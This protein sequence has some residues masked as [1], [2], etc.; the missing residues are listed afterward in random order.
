MPYKEMGVLYV[1]S[2]YLDPGS[3]GLY[4]GTIEPLYRYETMKPQTIYID[5]NG[6]GFEP[7]FGHSYMMHGE[8]FYGQTSLTA[9]RLTEFSSVAAERA[10]IEGGA[11]AA[12]CDVSDVRKTVRDD[13]DNPYVKI[14]RVY[15]V[16][17]NSL[18]VHATSDMAAILTFH[19]GET[20]LLEGRAFTAAEYALGSRVCV[21]SSTTASI[22]GVGLGDK[23]PLFVVAA[24]DMPLYESYWPG[25]RETE[26]DYE[27]VGIVSDTQDLG[28]AVYIPKP[29]SMRGQTS[30]VGYTIG[31]AL[32]KNG[33]ADEFV[34]RITPHLTERMRLTVYDQGYAA[35]AQPIEEVRETASLVTVACVI[36]AA[37]VLLLFAYLFVYRQ[38]ETYEI[39][40]LT[41]ASARDSV[42]YL[43]VSCGVVA[44]LGAALGAAGGYLFADRLTVAM[45]EDAGTA[46]AADLRYST[47]GLGIV[48]DFSI[49]TVMEPSSAVF[50]WAAAAVFAAACAL[51]AGFLF[52][53]SRPASGR[54]V[55]AR[56]KPR[57]ARLTAFIARR[58]AKAAPRRSHPSGGALAYALTSIARGG[59]RSLAAPAA[60]LAITV[61]ISVISSTLA[62]YEARLDDVYDMDISAYATSIS[63]RAISGLAVAEEEVEYLKGT[64]YVTDV[65]VSV[66]RIYLYAGLYSCGDVPNADYAPPETPRS[67]Y[68]Y[69]TWFNGVLRGPSVIY[70]TDMAAS[71]EFFY[72]GHINA[73]YAPGLDASLLAAPV[74]A[75]GY[76]LFL[77]P[78][79]MLAERGLEYGDVIAI[80]QPVSYG[81]FY[82]WYFR[83]AGSFERESGAENI[84][85]QLGA[86]YTGTT[87]NDRYGEPVVTDEV[88]SFGVLRFNVASTEALTPLK[89][90]LESYGFSAVQDL[91]R[92]RTAI[93]I[94]DDAFIESVSSL[95]KHISRLQAL[96]PAL[97]ALTM[98]IGYV[99]SYLLMLSRRGEMAVMRLL[100]AQRGRMFLSFFLEQAL[101]CLLGAAAALALWLLLSPFSALQLRSVLLFAV[102][103]FLGSALSVAVMNTAKVMTAVAEKE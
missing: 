79:S 90:A 68:A 29:L 55:K 92:S 23:I 96:Y 18:T 24:G 26:H 20:Y 69:E 40:V 15:R 17:N 1:H 25:G 8:F 102:C 48:K 47:A 14:A 93:V 34:S 88:I 85:C 44:L 50:A 91:N 12:Y 19:Q 63:G 64:G 30:V 99:V 53:I 61:F 10:G 72:S 100:G 95:T 75:D 49:T 101:L 41:G 87:A 57:P 77:V 5:P 13:E 60:A 35:V 33:R 98:V 80:W 22:M 58:R 32:L 70:T 81:V 71:S 65:A 16:M 89:D 4:M 39:F 54:P 86:V 94:D 52:L 59:A 7:E 37:A 28:Q 2:I 45:F 21:I 6:T 51:S 9:F 83:V 84:Y 27:I 46:V 66:E 74:P 103:Y 62:T 97:F 73:A 38:R 76:P 31:Q 36:A 78:D 3:S 56:K 42:T 11:V 67:S 43:L 82:E